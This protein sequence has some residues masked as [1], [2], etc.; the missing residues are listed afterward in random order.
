MKTYV[1]PGLVVGLLAAACSG[2]RPLD[3]RMKEWVG[4]AEAELQRSWGKPARIELRDGYKI[5][6]YQTT[7]MVM[8]GGGGGDIKPVF[9]ECTKQVFIRDGKVAKLEWNSNW[10]TE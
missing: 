9:N 3:V 7:E 6:T 8:Q 5:L 1:V 4:H 2:L 10:C